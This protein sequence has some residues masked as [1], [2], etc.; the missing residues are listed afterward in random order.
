[1]SNTPH[2]QKRSVNDQNLDN[3]STENIE[4]LD[5]PFSIGEIKKTISTLKRNKSCDLDNTV[6][7]FFIDTKDFI[8]HYLCLIFNKIQGS[9]Q[10]LVPK[11]S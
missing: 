7:D 8:S 10:I 3:D 5:Q 1:M 9:I 11:V 6:A 4:V 2:E